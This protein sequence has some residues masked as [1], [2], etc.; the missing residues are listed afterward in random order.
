MELVKG[1]VW[2]KG[3][4]FGR[5]REGLTAAEGS[6]NVLV[7]M[8]AVIDQPARFSVVLIAT[9]WVCMCDGTDDD[10]DDDD[11]GNGEDRVELGGG[12]EDARMIM[13]QTNQVDPG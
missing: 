1:C 9:E 10:D 4:T 6:F 5:F 7:E 11:D 2:R 12:G 3:R 8:V 13:R